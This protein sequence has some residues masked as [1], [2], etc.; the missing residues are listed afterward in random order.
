MIRRLV[1]AAAG[2]I[3]GILGRRCWDLYRDPDPQEDTD[4]EHHGRHQ[5]T[6]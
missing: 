5:H 3:L 2:Y 6:H 4:D 1:A